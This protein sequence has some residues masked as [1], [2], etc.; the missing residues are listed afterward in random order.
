LNKIEGEITRGRL[1]ASV[2]A[3]PQRKMRLCEDLHGRATM[4][5]VGAPWPTMEKG[6]RGNEEGER[7]ALGGCRRGG[8]QAAMEGCSIRL[9]H[10]SVAAIR[11]KEQEGEEEKRRKR[12]E[13]KKGRKKRKIKKGKFQTWNFLK[14]KR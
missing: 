14:N 3:I 2:L 11:E 4:A 13:R 1:Y 7:R 8:R 10:C 12:K 6:K 9:L 5:G